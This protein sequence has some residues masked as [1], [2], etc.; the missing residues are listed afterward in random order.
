MLANYI[1]Q[2]LGAEFFLTSGVAG[3]SDS[4]GVADENVRG[5]EAMSSSVQFNSEDRPRAGRMQPLDFG[6]IAAKE[7]SEIVSAIDVLQ[8]SGTGIEFAAEHGDEAAAILHGV[9]F[10][11]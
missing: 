3:F 4:V 9:E 2:A 1:E 11:V 5:R 10:I 6:T 7:E 8:A